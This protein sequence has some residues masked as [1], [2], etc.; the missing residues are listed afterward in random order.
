MNFKAFKINQLTC[1][2]SILVRLPAGELFERPEQEKRAYLN[3]GE[4]YYKYGGYQ[5]A[6]SESRNGPRPTPGSPP[7]NRGR[8]EF[9]L[10]YD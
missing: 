6:V 5:K 3:S 1:F 8:G 10:W 7:R 4:K 9:A 2:S